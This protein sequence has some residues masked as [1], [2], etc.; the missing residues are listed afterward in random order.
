M[1]ETKSLHYLLVKIHTDWMED[2][3]F[4]RLW[5]IS[6]NRHIQIFPRIVINVPTMA[7]SLVMLCLVSKYLALSVFF[8]LLELLLFSQILTGKFECVG[9][10][11]FARGV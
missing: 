6:S 11:K 5:Q 8:V 7:L 9:W 1:S 2:T 4:T 3:S 10:K